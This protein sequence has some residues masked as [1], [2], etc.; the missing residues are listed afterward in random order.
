[1]YLWIDLVTCV[2]SIK[3]ISTLL[4][5]KCNI[6]YICLDCFTHRERKGPVFESQ[7]FAQRSHT[8]SSLDL[9]PPVFSV[10]ADRYL[11]KGFPSVSVDIVLPLFTILIYQ[12]SFI[13]P[14]HSCHYS[15]S[16]H[17]HDTVVTSPGRGEGGG[18]SGWG[19]LR[20]KWWTL[21]LS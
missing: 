6:R 14:H 10:T 7:V 4:P 21:F 19:S 3:F 9:Q 12:L 11:S 2:E 15:Q 18:G 13:R 16:T 8:A 1:M 20:Q 5:S 17:S